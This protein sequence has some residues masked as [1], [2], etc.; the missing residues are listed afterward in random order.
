MDRHFAL[1]ELLVRRALEVQGATIKDPREL[2]RTL[3]RSPPPHTAV[4][5]VKMDL[6]FLDC[7]R[8]ATSSK[9]YNRAA[10]GLKYARQV[11]FLPGGGFACFRVP[12]H[13]V[14]IKVRPC[15]QLLGLWLQSSHVSV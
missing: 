5:L 4:L 2:Y 1:M 8:T 11:K 10:R 7:G 15:V 6:D 14:P 3:M 13:T 12:G 9:A